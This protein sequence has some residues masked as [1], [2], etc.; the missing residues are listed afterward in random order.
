[1]NKI[2][3]GVIFGA[4]NILSFAYFGVLS[5]FLLNISTFLGGAAS[6]FRGVLHHL[7]SRD[8]RVKGLLLAYRV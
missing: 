7:P 1:M 8:V 4:G 2:V 3:I 6:P 5:P